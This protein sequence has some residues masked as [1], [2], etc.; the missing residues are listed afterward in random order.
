M[1]LCTYSVIN[2]GFSTPRQSQQRVYIQWRTKI[3]K[4]K[5]RTTRNRDFADCKILCRVSKIGH[6]TKTFFTECYTR[7]RIALGK[8]GHSAKDFFAERQTRQN[9]NTRHRLPVKRRPIT[10]FFAE[11]LRLGTRQIFFFVFNFFAECPRSG[12]RQRCKFFLKKF[13]A[14]R[15]RSGARQRKFFYF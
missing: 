2:I 8:H 1:E 11:R 9:L 4:T 13:F 6:S 12:T 3:H 10:A 15:L 14:E 5:P 7:Q